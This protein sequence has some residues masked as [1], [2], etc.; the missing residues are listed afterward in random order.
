MLYKRISS[1]LLILLSTSFAYAQSSG[2]LSSTQPDYR[3]NGT[4]TLASNFVEKGLTQTK[5]D[6]GLQSDFWFNFGSQFRM[7]L[8][9]AN[10]RYDSTQTTHFW[11][12]ANADVKVDFSDSVKMNIIYNEN[13]YFK[14]NNRDGNTVGIHFDFWGWKIIYDMDSNWEGTRNGATYAGAGKDTLIGGGSW[15]WS[16]QG[17]YTMPK[18]D[19]VN[20]FFD[21]RSGIGSK[22]KDFI[23]M[24]S[25][26]YTTATGEFKDQGQLAFILSATVGF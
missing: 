5:G 4:A 17:G 18:A 23:L 10:V 7:G 26:T 3:L 24:G 6:P 9:G 11:L 8:W 21:I 1:L 12:K 14:A 2:G 16:N 20:G 15:I 13:K 19:G 22:L 25:L